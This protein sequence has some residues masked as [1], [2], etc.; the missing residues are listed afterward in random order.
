MIYLFIYIRIQI[1]NTDLSSLL[2][3]NNVKIK[4]S[5]HYGNSDEFLLRI[6]TSFYCELPKLGQTSMDT[7]RAVA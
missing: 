3:Y 4:F 2:R 6:K 1:P 5:F 7:L